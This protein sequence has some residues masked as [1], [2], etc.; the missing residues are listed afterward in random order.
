MKHAGDSS[1]PSS[2]R[3]ITAGPAGPIVVVLCRAGHQTEGI[4]QDLPAKGHTEIACQCL[5]VRDR[6]LLHD[7][8]ITYT[9]RKIW[10]RI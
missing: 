9:Y 1:F 3:S 7:R 10:P 2:Y 4:H 6:H 5:D 8:G